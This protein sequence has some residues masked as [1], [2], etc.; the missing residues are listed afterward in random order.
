M[1]ADDQVFV[2][3]KEDEGASPASP[4]RA[5]IMRAFNRLTDTMWPGVVTL[6]SMAVGASDGRY[7]RAA[8][9]PVYSLSG[10]FNERDDNRAHGRDERMAVKSYFEGQTFM[11]EIVKSLAQASE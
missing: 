4:M 11:Y 5:D 10:L 8:G 7:L 2:T 1:V 3:I 6:P 9:I